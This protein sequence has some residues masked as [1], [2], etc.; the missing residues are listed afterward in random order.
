M[1]RHPGPGQP[2]AARARRRRAAR[3]RLR[4]GLQPA[5]S[6]RVSRGARCRRAGPCSC[7]PRSAIRRWAW[8]SS[9]RRCAERGRIM[10]NSPEE[11][12]LSRRV[13]GTTEVPGVTVGVGSR[14][15]IG[16]PIPTAPGARSAWR[17]RSSSTSAASTRTRA[18]RISS[19]TSCASARARS[20]RSIW[21]SSARR[22]CRSRHHPRIRHLGYVSD[23][24]KFDVIAARGGAGDAV[25]LREPVDGGARG[26]GARPAGA[27]QRTLRRPGRP[28]PAQQRRPVLHERAGVRGHAGDAARRARRLGADGPEW[29]R[30]ST[31][32]TTPGRSSRA[33]TW[34]C[35]IGLPTHAPPAAAPS[36]CRAGSRRRRRRLPP[37]ATVVAALPSGSGPRPGRIGESSIVKLAFVTPRYGA[38]IVTGPEHA[39]R[40]LAEHISRR[41]DVDVITTC[42]RHA[43][44]WKNEYAEGP[45]SRPGRAHPA[46][47]GVSAGEPATRRRPWRGS[48]ANP[49]AAPTNSIGCRQSGPWSAGLLEHLKQHQHAYDA[50]V[51]FSMSAATT[52]FGLPM[53]PARSVLFPY[54]QLSPDAAARP[55]GRGADVGAGHRPGVGGGAAADAALRPRGRHPRRGGRHRHRALAQDMPIRGTSRI[56]PTTRSSDDGPAPDDDAVGGVAARR[57]RHAL[58]PPPP[59]LRFVRALR[60]ARRARQRLPGDA[61]LLRH[62]RDRRTA[63]RCRSC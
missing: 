54:L 22:C 29:T 11:R 43:G 59:P 57:P 16:V 26:L 12:A 6:H 13:A 37:A 62:L 31:R 52:V 3:V 9:D 23:Q 21:C 1:A 7:R 5:L 51:F 28:V 17:I 53:A 34:A 56:P 61:G 40:L 38:D 48:R 32:P 36:R 35:S 20:G 55:V 30:A 45:G 44:S 14:C 27:R 2:G 49:T 33:S 42:A 50:V 25:A 24:D 8:R 46:L 4:G 58:P 18:A 15:P 60:R 41:H 47:P 10:Y 63:I 19:T 39:C